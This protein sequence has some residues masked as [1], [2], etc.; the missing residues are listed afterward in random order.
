M[1]RSNS[2]WGKFFDHLIPKLRQ[3]FVLVIFL[4]VAFAVSQLSFSPFQLAIIYSVLLFLFV[5]WLTKVFVEVD[6]SRH[7]KGFIVLISGLAL[8]VAGFYSSIQ[9][10]LEIAANP[11]ASFGQYLYLFFPIFIML[12]GALMLFILNFDNQITSFDLAAKIE[13]DEPL[14]GDFIMVAL[15]TVVLILLGDFII[16]FPWYLNICLVLMINLIVIN[17][18]GG[19]LEEKR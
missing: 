14:V 19:Q 16:N 2:T 17:Q 7:Y 5:V 13:I 8:F 12:E 1:S 6:S 10:Y 9:Y 18:F 4:M 15:A 3:E 11:A